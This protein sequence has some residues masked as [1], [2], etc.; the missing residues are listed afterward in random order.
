MD[1]TVRLPNEDEQLRKAF[2][3]RVPGLTIREAQSGMEYQV[4]DLSSS[5][6]AILDES[7]AFKE[8]R[9]IDFDLLLARK[10]FLQGVKGK[11]RRILDNGIVGC[12]FVELNQRQEAK[13]DK[14]VLEVQKRLI[15]LRKARKEEP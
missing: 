10:L 8:G 11:V 7:R 5:G 4:K 2:R 1:F 13:L 15:E 14:L 3:T 6:F 9:T 12:N